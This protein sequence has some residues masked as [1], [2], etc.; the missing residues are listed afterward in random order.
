MDKE[1]HLCVRD[2]IVYGIQDPDVPAIESPGCKPFTYRALREQIS[3]VVKSLNARGLRPNDRVAVIMQNG[4]D[5]AVT[6]LAVM[7]GFTV[8]PFSSQYKKPEYDSFFSTLGIKAVLV[9][10]GEKTAAIAVAGAQQIPVIEVSSSQETA[11]LFALIP[12][13][14]YGG[15][16]AL[17]AIPQ[18]IAAIKI[19]TGTTATP[20]MVPVTQKRFFS[21]VNRLNASFDLNSR[22]KNLHFLPLDTGFGFE[23]ALG[24]SLLTGGTLV[25]LRDFIPSDFLGLLRYF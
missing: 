8:V 17:Y 11:G 7:A 12:E 6:I 15:R 5:A 24:G 21:G 9:Q 18:D 16:E 3:Y 23:T 20:K 1:E 14:D 4:P 25:C 2:L 10:K 13:V 22:D 19:T